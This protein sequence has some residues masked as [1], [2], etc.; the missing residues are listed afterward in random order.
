MI[1]QLREKHRRILVAAAFRGKQFRDPSSEELSGWLYYLNNGFSPAE[2][3]C[4]MRQRGATPPAEQRSIT[5]LLTKETIDCVTDS[6]PS[7]PFTVIDWDAVQRVKSLIAA[8]A[9]C[10]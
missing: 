2:M 1:E 7:E 3:I 6:E 4:A 10:I 8:K 9:Q 5:P